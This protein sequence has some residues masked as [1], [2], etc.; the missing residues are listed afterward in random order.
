M[1][2]Q[3]FKLLTLCLVLL[4]GSCVSD[5]LIDTPY[6]GSVEAGGVFIRFDDDATTRSSTIVGTTPMFNEGYLLI[7]SGSTVARYYRIHD[8]T[9][10][11]TVLA[12]RELYIEDLKNPGVHLTTP[13]SG[14]TSRLV[15]VGNTELTNPVV[16]AGVNVNTLTAQG[17]GILVHTQYNVDE[18]NLWGET[19]R[20][21]WV[22]N[23][24]VSEPWDY[25]V[26][27]RLYP[28]VA[29]I[30]MQQIDACHTGQ[31]DRFTVEG[32]FIDRH[33]D[34]AHVNGFI[35]GAG[36]APTFAPTNFISR[37][38]APPVG[39]QFLSGQHGYGNIGD[40]SGAL[41]NIVGVDRIG[42]G[43]LGNPFRVDVRTFPNN[44]LDRRWAYNLF[45]MRP[46]L[47]NPANPPVPS[48]ISSQGTRVPSI[49]IRL[50]GV[51]LRGATT[52]LPGNADGYHYLTI[53]E[54]LYNGTPLT[55]IHASN[56]YHINSLAFTEEHLGL[57][58]NENPKRVNVKVTLAQWNRQE[59]RPDSF[60]QPNPIGGNAIAV[61]D[62]ISFNFPFLLGPAFCSACANLDN[63]QYLWQY[64]VGGVDPV[65][66]DI[67]VLSAANRTHTAIGLEQ[68][69]Y[70]RRVAVCTCPPSPTRVTRIVSAV[71]R[72]ELSLAQPELASRNVC[73]STPINLGAAVPSAGVTYRWESTPAPL[74]GGSVWTTVGVGQHFVT[75]SW[76][77][78]HYLRRVAILNG[79]DFPGNAAL[80]TVPPRLPASDFPRTASITI[81]DRITT[82]ATRNVDL[83]NPHPNSHY[84]GFTYHP[85]DPGMFFQWG[86][87]YGWEAGPTG[88]H[89]PARRW[90][91]AYG[92]VGNRWQEVGGPWSTDVH[93][94]ASD[95]WNGIDGR[96]NAGPCPPGFRLPTRQ[97][98]QDMVAVINA[99]NGS[100]R[101]LNNP[102]F[103]CLAGHLL[104]TG[105]N[106]LFMPAA[107]VRN[108]SGMVDLVN[109]GGRYWTDTPDNTFNLG[110]GM[111]FD[112]HSAGTSTHWRPLGMPIRCVR[113]VQ[114]KLLPQSN[115]CPGST[116]TLGAA[117]P[118][119]SGII[120][121]RW[122]A[123]T[124]PLVE[125]SWT[126]IGVASS[127][128]NVQ[129][130]AWSLNHYLRR[131]AIWDGEEFPS[132]HAFM[133]MVT[134]GDFPRTV[135][136]TYQ[137]RTT[138]W[139]TRNV[140]LRNPHPD[141]AFAGFAYHP[142]DVGMYFQWGLHYGWAYPYSWSAQ[143][144]GSSPTRRWNPAVGTP[145]NRWEDATWISPVIATTWNSFDG[146]RLNAGPCPPG[147]RLPRLQEIQDLFGI[148]NSAAPF[149]NSESMLHRSPEFGCVSGIFTGTGSNRLFLPLAGMLVPGDWLHDTHLVE[150][151]FLS[152]GMLANFWGATSF[153]FLYAG[154]E[155]GV[156]PY[157]ATGGSLASGLPVRCVSTQND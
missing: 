43:V 81:N 143:G 5:S 82:W 155:W 103:G 35:P 62:P 66:N 124:T 45:A 98:M 71:A 89:M 84:A 152:V 63:I 85:G 47:I 18:L 21:N 32:I 132:N 3:L 134:R 77:V 104:G 37:G 17:G 97:E 88:H 86:L 145:D 135:T 29:R 126:A 112:Q 109:T 48:N 39:F 133:S 19:P 100:W 38:D 91:P 28:T 22:P 154:L 130:P 118:A 137:G 115:L 50:S 148:I 40:T 106:K 116:I 123:T 52:D 76:S 4:L 34:R 101:T 138:V 56:I 20:S 59:T 58:P 107:G 117:T 64:T 96:A 131:V 68:T 33:Y 95:M 151:T 54:F 94:T 30:E 16:A 70:F 150:G 12:N 92:T 147:F 102:E 6:N 67:G 46:V 122:E 111:F 25:D 49:V 73:T 69:T 153:G 24:N 14:A 15:I 157:E 10:T 90:N 44:N 139:A 26:T 27:I 93:G 42:A 57:T 2:K 127:N 141:P 105:A 144:L 83:S 78:N 125:S 1:T 36:V 114:P 128:T 87:N 72:V 156:V 149:P 31:I 74:T 61:G 129:I 121:Y 79:E 41:F 110:L 65:W 140:D 142:A 13:V 23:T 11:G 108:T 75:P 51:R 8:D 80:M 120:M 7:V 136:V 146:T 113:F 99:T 9:G 55:G 53:R 119:G 60:H